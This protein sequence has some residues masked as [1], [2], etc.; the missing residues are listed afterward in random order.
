MHFGALRVLNDDIVAPGMGF[1]A[2][3]HDNMEIVSITIEGDLAHKDSE[4]NGSIIK[5]NDVQIMSAGTGIF[6]SEH[7][8]G[9]NTKVN[10]LQIWVFP[11]EHDI[12]P[13]Y[14]QKTFSREERRNRFQVVV[15][16]DEK[17]GALAINQDSWFSLGI[18]DANFETEYVV[19]KPGNGVYAFLI[20]GSARIAE[21][22]LGLR[23]GMGIW[24]AEQFSLKAIEECE[25]LMIE[26]PMR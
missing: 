1:G 17:N 18:F 11:K 7:N 5:K 26:V 4:G 15:S 2:H 3:P 20:S 14:G 19:H 22:E 21:M 25:I 23:D 12:K 16:P 10:F 13:R 6:H 8:P 9:A 24:D